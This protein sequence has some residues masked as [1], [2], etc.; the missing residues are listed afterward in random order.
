MKEN[1]VKITKRVHAFKA[2]SSSCNVE[3]FKFF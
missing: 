3:I 1:N 2:Y